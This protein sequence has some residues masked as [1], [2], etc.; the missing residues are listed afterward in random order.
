MANEVTINVD[1]DAERTKSELSSFQS[2]MQKFSAGVR[3][4][5]LALTAMGVE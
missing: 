2:Q 3:K 5:G 4:A 1:V